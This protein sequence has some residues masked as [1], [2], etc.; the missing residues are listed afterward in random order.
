ME[1][2]GAMPNHLKWQTLW[3]MEMAYYSDEA[4]SEETGATAGK[5]PASSKETPHPK[6]PN[7]YWRDQQVGNEAEKEKG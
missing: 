6:A 1:E 5:A 4:T 7:T 2:W 3:D